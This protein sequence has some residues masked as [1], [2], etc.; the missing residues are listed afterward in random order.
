MK[1]D[2][3][4]FGEKGILLRRHGDDAGGHESVNL[5]ACD[6]CIEA[7]GFQRPTLHFLEPYQGKYH[8]PNWYMQ[9]FPPGQLHPHRLQPIQHHP[10]ETRTDGRAGEPTICALNSTWQEAFGSVGGSQIGLFTRLLLVFLLDPATRPSRAAM[11]RW[12]DFMVRWKHGLRVVTHIEVY[13]WLAVAVASDWRLWPWAGFIVL[14]GA[15]P[16]RK[17]AM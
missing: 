16:P 17:G 4:Q 7:T 9:V 15:L 8:P 10:S 12:V 3:I 5:E 6:V 14:G 1:G 13:L 11:E 2:C